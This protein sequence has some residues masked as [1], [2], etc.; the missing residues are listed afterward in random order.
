MKHVK[1]TLALFASAI[2][3]MVM[4]GQS[5][6]RAIQLPEGPGKD[7]T[8]KVCGTTC[9][10][11]DIVAGTGRTHNQWTG[12][13]N[14][15]VARGAKASDTELH[16]IVN[17]LSSHF[18]PDMAPIAGVARPSGPGAR[19]SRGAL[20]KGP[21][22]LGGGAADSH[23]VDDQSADRGKSVYI[24]ECITCHGNKGRGGS[25]AY[26]S[27]CRQNFSTERISDGKSTGLRRHGTPRMRSTSSGCTI[28]VMQTTGTS[29]SAG[30]S[31]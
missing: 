9:H 26:E 30:S 4:Q 1:V 20:G 22:P 25:E 14:S 8:Q 31:S 16:Q 2:F 21:G 15:M 3:P 18:G 28:P 29:A 7:V 24:A 6:R 13:V 27:G 19:P 12:V 11:P 23:V 17:Y 10:G 5:E